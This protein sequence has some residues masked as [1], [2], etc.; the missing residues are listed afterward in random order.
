MLDKD[1]RLLISM[2]SFPG[3]FAYKDLNSKFIHCNKKL[4]QYVGSKNSDALAGKTDADFQWAE[5]SHLYRQHELDAINGNAYSGIYPS[6]SLCGDSILIMCNRA[7]KYDENDNIIGVY[8][9]AFVAQNTNLIK[10]VNALEKNPLLEPKQ[11]YSY[12]NKNIVSC[13]T[14]REKEILFLTIYG[15]TAREIGKIL[16]LSN[17][18]IENYLDTIKTKEYVNRS[19]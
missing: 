13:I 6:T 18:T 17:R 9:Y 14:K 7:P 2:E 11:H 15:K 10:L 5:Y 8:G 1:E 12:H 19:V 4:A 3:W 16:Q